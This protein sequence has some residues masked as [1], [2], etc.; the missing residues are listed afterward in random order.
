MCFVLALNHLDKFKEL[1]CS[2]HLPALKH[3]HFSFC[4][5]KPLADEWKMSLL[6][7]NNGWPFDDVDCYIDEGLFNDGTV[8]LITEEIFVIYKRPIDILFQYKRA[9]YNHHFLRLLSSTST[10]KTE[11]RPSVVWYCDEIDKHDELLKSL[12]LIANDRIDQLILENKR[13]LVSD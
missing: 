9:L 12:E 13:E 6:N 1:C 11:Q 7:V 10:I 5:P 3:L 2:D 4:F 8:V